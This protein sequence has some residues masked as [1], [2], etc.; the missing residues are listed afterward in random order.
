[1]GPRWTGEL[2]KGITAARRSSTDLVFAVPRVFKDSTPEDTAAVQPVIDQIVMYPLSQF[3]GTMKTG[4]RG[5]VQ[6]PA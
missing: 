1:V 3:D 2:L 6:L 4:S 5:L